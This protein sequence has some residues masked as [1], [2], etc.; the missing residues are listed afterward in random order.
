MRTKK[1]EVFE[2]TNIPEAENLSLLGGV[3]FAAVLE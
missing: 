2:K 3:G 1:R